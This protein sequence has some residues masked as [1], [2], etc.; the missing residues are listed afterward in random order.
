ML[1]TIKNE[2]NR[3][4]N[5]IEKLEKIKKEL[6]VSDYTFNQHKPITYHSNTPS[7]SARRHTIKLNTSGSTLFGKTENVKRQLS[8]ID[9]EDRK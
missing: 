7:K 8:I 2:K 6:D 9:G 1:K 5:H 3:V 4:E